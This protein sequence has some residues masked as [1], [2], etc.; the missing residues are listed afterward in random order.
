[1]LSWKR[2]WR[3]IKMSTT[4]IG[5]LTENPE[6]TFTYAGNAIT[7]FSVAVSLKKGNQEHVTHFQCSSWGTLAKGIADSLHKG[8]RIIVEGRLLQEPDETADGTSIIRNVVFA[9]AVGP[10]L[11]FQTAVVSQ[12]PKSVK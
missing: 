3:G 1:M 10:D 4:I 12:N 11:R 2:I 8:D 9:E 5:R 6:T 7:R